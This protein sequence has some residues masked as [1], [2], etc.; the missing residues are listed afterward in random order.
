MYVHTTSF[1]IHCCITYLANQSLT[2]VMKLKRSLLRL[3]C[4][5]T[6]QMHLSKALI[7]WEWTT[8]FENNKLNLFSYLELV[9]LEDSQFLAYYLST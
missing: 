8:Y 6:R 4:I 3:K 1:C 7:I 2:L 5:M 9:V